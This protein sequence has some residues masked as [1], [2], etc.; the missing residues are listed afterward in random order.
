MSHSDFFVYDDYN[1]NEF[2]PQL[3][4]VAS[5]VQKGDK[6]TIFLIVIAT[7]AT[8]MILHIIESLLASSF[9]CA[10]SLLELPDLSS[11]QVQGEQTMCE[12]T[13]GRRTL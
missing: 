8:E 2:T 9:L 3:T 7:S 13:S 6:S 10:K 12:T 1:E 4:L 5:H 11:T